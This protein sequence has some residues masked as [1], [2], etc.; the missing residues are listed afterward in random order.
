M[1]LLVSRGIWLLKLVGSVVGLVI[2]GFSGR[3]DWV[4]CSGLR[5]EGLTCMYVGL[6]ILSRHISLFAMDSVSQ[7][8][9]LT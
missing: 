7:A 3:I 1:F 8:C 5:L 9:L 4:G 6:R 2:D